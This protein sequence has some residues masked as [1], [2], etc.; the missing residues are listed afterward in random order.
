MLSSEI[1]EILKTQK[2][3]R[4]L[5]FWSGFLAILLIG[6]LWASLSK[7]P[8]GPGFGDE[9]VRIGMA[10]VEAPSVGVTT[11]EAR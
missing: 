9:G 3:R 11:E 2:R 1:G 4:R 7:D 10:T 8:R 5:V 6:T